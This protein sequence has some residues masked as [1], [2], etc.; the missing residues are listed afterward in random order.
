MTRKTPSHSL[1]LVHKRNLPVPVGPLMTHFP[2]ML[3]ECGFIPPHR[4]GPLSEWQRGH[5]IDSLPK[6][7]PQDYSPALAP[8]VIA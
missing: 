8:I 3:G 6:E 5:H 7:P 1:H 2:G 4:A